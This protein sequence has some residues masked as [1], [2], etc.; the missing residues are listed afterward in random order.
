MTYHVYYPNSFANFVLG[1]VSIVQEKS[2]KKDYIKTWIKHNISTVNREIRKLSIYSLTLNL[3]SRIQNCFTEMST[4]TKVKD[5]QGQ[6]RNL[7]T[8]NKTK[9]SL[10][11]A[12]GR[13]DTIF[14]PFEMNVNYNE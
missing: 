2:T 6:Q 10:L 4:T 7:K 1:R 13:S 14:S 5:A 11:G 12:V 8:K 3:K 9:S